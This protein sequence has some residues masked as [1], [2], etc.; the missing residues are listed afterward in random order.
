MKQTLNDIKSSLM[1][2]VSWMLPFVVAGG[3]L[4]ALGF[5]FGG[6]NI[7]EAVEPYGTFISSIYWIGQNAFSLMI[8]VLGAYIAYSIAD[9]PALASG[10]VGGLLADEMDAG[11]LGA[12][13][14]W[15]IA[16]FFV[17]ELKKIPVP[18]SM[19]SVLSTL[20]IPIISVVG[21]GLLMVYI[22]GQP[23][24]AITS[25]MISW[26]NS[27]SSANAVIL[28]IITGCMYAFDL[29]GPF[30]KASYAFAL[31]ASAGGNW[32]PMAAAALACMTPPLGIGIAMLVQKHRF[33]KEE[34]ASI[35][36]LITGGIAQITEFAIPFAVENPIRVIPALMA[37]SSVASVL[38]YVTGLTMHAPH[39]GIFVILLYNKPLLM[40]LYLLIGSCVTALCF[41]L[42]RKDPEELEEN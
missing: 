42:L 20:I 5:L 24:M 8:P 11:F 18:G 41:L 3:I 28:G 29:G 21:I 13:I 23:V 17:R 10:M 32:E 22:I 4:V 7:E 2:G 34:R 14:A 35:P 6:I 19:R 25:G 16:G 15:I 36:G 39:G 40:I 27:M 31:A 9:K 12:L 30:N 38:A 1:T 26:L 37:G 33:T